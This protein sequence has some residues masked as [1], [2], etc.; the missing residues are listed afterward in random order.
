MIRAARAPKVA[1]PA[2]TV[3]GRRFVRAVTMRGLAERVL[4]KE[5]LRDNE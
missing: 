5:L 2:R 3:V 4:I 1:L